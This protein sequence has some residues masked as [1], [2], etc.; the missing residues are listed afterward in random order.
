MNTVL[1]LAAEFLGLC[2]EAWLNNVVVLVTMNA[3]V[4][5]YCRG[6]RLREMTSTRVLILSSSEPLCHHL[7]T[8][9]GNAFHAQDTGQ[10]M[11]KKFRN[12]VVL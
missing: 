6:G 2:S 10:D 4:T 7:I 11:K 1:L 9:K 5:F 12:K 8:K 3:I